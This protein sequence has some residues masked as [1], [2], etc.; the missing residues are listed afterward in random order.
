MSASTN[1][2][3][4][5]VPVKPWR[6]AKSRLAVPGRDRAEVARALSL[7]TIETVHH[8]DIVERIVVVS[9]EVELAVAV[10]R[11]SKVVVRQDRPMLA[12][13]MLNPAVDQGRW[14]AQ[15]EA[16]E[17][18]VVVVPADL[19]ALT[20]DVLDCAL[21]RLAEH[22]RAHVPDLRGGGTTLLAARQ[23]LRL[24]SRYGV[25]SA[26]MHA[27]RGSVPVLDVDPRVR[28]DVDDVEDLKAARRWGLAPRIGAL[29]APMPA[30]T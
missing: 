9:V 14:W 27:E 16:P 18:P 1:G 2:W 6:L 23:P 28:L 10:S 24:E 22:E 20:T 11:L 8:S 12:V 7:D 13:D 5:I 29:V 3:T 25:D 15:S 21:A 17:S 26:R 30:V 4:A 19:A